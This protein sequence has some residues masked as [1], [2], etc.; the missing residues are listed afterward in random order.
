MIEVHLFIFVHK[1]YYTSNILWGHTA[2]TLTENY[3]ALCMQ[4][5]W[6]MQ[7]LLN[8]YCYEIV[9]TRHVCVRMFLCER[10]FFHYELDVNHCKY[11]ALSSFGQ[12][13][14]HF[15]TPWTRLTLLKRY[16]DCIVLECQNVYL[17]SRMR[18]RISAWNSD[19]WESLH[20][21]QN[22]MYTD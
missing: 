13:F 9:Y 21:I 10:N 2:L 12:V 18:R 16:V 3:F 8:V 15:W 22:L 1:K 5:E 17:K 14:V 11:F 20:N 7:S 4:L 19:W 6:L